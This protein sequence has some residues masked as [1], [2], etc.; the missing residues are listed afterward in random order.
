MPTQSVHALVLAALLLAAPL[1]AAQEDDHDAHH[2]E[3]SELPEAP[4][5]T[6][7]GTTAPGMMGEGMMGPGMMTPEMME[8]MTPEMMQ[9]MMRMMGQGMMRPG[10]PGQGMM[11]QGMMG[12]RTMGQGAMG[13]QG[14][15]GTMP[16]QG[17]GPG[18]TGQMPMAM[19]GGDPLLYGSPHLTPEPMTPERVRELLQQR[20]DDHGNPRLQLGAIAEADDGSITAEI[21]TTDGALVQKLAFNR[22]PGLV[23]Q[24][25]D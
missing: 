5:T 6:P 22:Y 3:G 9:M 10:M 21:I 20:L 17:V 11:G 13:G 14:M 4:G 1:A 8:M 18:M 15:P 23:R 12:Q 2:P 7:E 25:D 16:R 24:L 19:P